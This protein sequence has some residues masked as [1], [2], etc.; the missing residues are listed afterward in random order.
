MCGQPCE[1]ILLPATRPSPQ[2]AIMSHQPHLAQAIAEQR[3][4]ELI[5]AAARYRLARAARL[6]ADTRGAGSRRRAAGEL[7]GRLRR[8]RRLQA[9]PE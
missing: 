9:L 4:A 3:Q 5:A 1:A 6:A 8:R 7:I 2:E